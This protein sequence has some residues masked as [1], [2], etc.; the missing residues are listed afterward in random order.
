MTVLNET[1]KYQQN[2]ITIEKLWL[3]FSLWCDAS[4]S[5]PLY[6]VLSAELCSCVIFLLR[7]DLGP[8]KR[9]WTASTSQ[10]QCLQQTV[11]AETGQWPTGPHTTK[12][13]PCVLRC[14]HWNAEHT[15]LMACI[16][17]SRFYAISCDNLNL[18][19]MWKMKLF[20]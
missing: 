13:L 15:Y 8:W 17:I 2:E 19:F 3:V 10:S 6:T 20:V 5:Y 1:I 16:V 18:I 12:E 7:S 14:I 11:R 9:S 4:G